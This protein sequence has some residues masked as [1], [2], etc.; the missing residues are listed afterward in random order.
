M[1]LSCGLPGSW[2]IW[3]NRTDLQRATR[4]RVFYRP[5]FGLY[6]KK[7]CTQK[8]AGHSNLKIWSRGL[9]WGVLLSCSLPGTWDISKNRTDLH[10][11]SVEN[12]F[13]G[14]KPYNSEITSALR[15]K[16]STIFKAYDQSKTNLWS[17]KSINLHICPIHLET[18]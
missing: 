11:F 6:L 10:S 1:S 17:K 4:I 14:D 8:E 3:K 13:G 9:F 16:S 5:I 2:D 18:T 12:G 15:K 7:Y